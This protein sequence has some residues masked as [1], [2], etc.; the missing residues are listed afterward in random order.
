[1][2]TEPEVTKAHI[3]DMQ[4]CVPDTWTDEQVIEFANRRNPS[5]LANGWGIRRT[6]DPALAGDPERTPCAGSE[7]RPG[8]VHIMLDC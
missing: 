3:F 4:V 2:N 8:F 1:M 5:G 6:G 7:G